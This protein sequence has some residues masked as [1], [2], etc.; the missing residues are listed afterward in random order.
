MYTYI[1]SSFGLL[2]LATLILALQFL[3]KSNAYFSIVPNEPSYIIYCILGLVFSK[4][5]DQLIKAQISEWQSNYNDLDKDADGFVSID[6]FASGHKNIASI[7]GDQFFDGAGKITFDQYC[8][9]M[10][11]FSDPA[12]GYKINEHRIKVRNPNPK[13]EN[14]F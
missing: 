5:I 7:I 14:G 3:L 6:E 12:L 2:K 4:T 8:L 10:V 9:Y 13:N 1:L 11:L